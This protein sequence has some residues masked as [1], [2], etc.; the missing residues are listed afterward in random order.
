[1][2]ALL[3]PL[4]LLFRLSTA[5][6]ADD[7]PPPPAATGIG[8]S[9]TAPPKH[10]GGVVPIA[11]VAQIPPWLR[12]DVALNYSYDRLG[13]HLNE[14]ELMDPGATESA[15]VQ[16]GQRTLN[17]HVLSI[18]AIFSAGPGVA[19]T[20]GLP[21]HIADSIDF[22]T[23]QTMVYDPTTGSGTMNGTEAVDLGVLAT[24]GGLEGAWI[25]IAGTPF[26]EAFAKRKNRVTWRIGG[27][28]RTPN[29]N[30]FYVETDGKRGAGDGGLGFR[31]DNAFSTTIG[32]SQPYITG[33]YQTDGKTSIDAV[34]AETRAVNFQLLDTCCSECICCC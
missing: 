18:D 27:A 4:S 3:L 11:T 19:V 12:G 5:Y 23:S 33:R 7:T 25:G 34:D 29:K 16:V 31:I 1:M 8:T 6:A 9:P 10:P 32:G 17:S 20:L 30:N 15:D 14:A 22:G 26:S 2:P 28:L 24:G 13:G 21:I